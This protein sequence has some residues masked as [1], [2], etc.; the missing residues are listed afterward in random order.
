[1]RLKDLNI[2]KKLTVSYSIL[3]LLTVV[4]GIT[5]L[6]SI[7]N[8][9]L[10]S[11]KVNKYNEIIIHLIDGRRYEKN[12]IINKDENSKTTVHNKFEKIDSIVNE[13]KI[14][15]KSQE[16]ILNTDSILTQSEIYITNFDAFTQNYEEV[17]DLVDKLNA[18]S[19]KI[20]KSNNGALNPI[21]TNYFEAFQYEKQYINFS[22]DTVYKQWKNRV[23]IIN[24][25]LKLKNLV[26]L[27]TLF[28]EYE[29]I[30]NKYCDVFLQKNKTENE[31]SKSAYIVK[32]TCLRLKDKANEQMH[33]NG[34]RG[35]F[36]LI[37]LI[38]FCIAVSIATGIIITKS[39]TTPL[40]KS[41]EFTRK[42]SKGNLTATIDI[43]QNDEVGILVNA[44]KSMSE[45]LR[46]IIKQ[47]KHN[48]DFVSVA[49]DQLSAT[50]QQ[51]S[52]GTTEQASVSEQIS[53]SMN[54]M[55]ASIRISADNTKQTQEIIS[56]T[57]DSVKNG[58]ALSIEAS[59]VMKDIAMKNTLIGEITFQTNLL[60]LNAAVEAARAGEYGRG[61]SVVANEVKKLA[62]DSKVAANE[63]NKLSK[64]G[65]D[66][67]EITAQKLSDIIPKIEK[68]V[69]LINGI[70]QINAEQSLEANNISNAMQQYNQVVQAN[71]AAAEE[72]ASNAEELN[73]QAQELR[74]K[75]SHFIVE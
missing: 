10:L 63:I 47:I 19:Q 70:N 33:S 61:F 41:I 44:L 42:I 67:S 24:N 39:I 27:S 22:S 43:S 49:S 64:Q 40:N 53:F 72:L 6:I 50:S 59:H 71:A 69:N 60:A 56:A 57:A 68:T 45:N 3:I 11:E 37:V 5:S 18:V 2:G 35:Y 51:I 16:N 74:K 65:L 30:F 26:G 46:S 25:Y 4:L 48:A 38:L 73:G 15:S 31:M 7:E 14:L 75:M 29:S 52:E 1:M 21:M 23:D 12:Y 55:L 28:N 17:K 34:R 58:S 54:E 66:V 62:E 9:S 13:L 8:I 32:Q 36:S 20:L